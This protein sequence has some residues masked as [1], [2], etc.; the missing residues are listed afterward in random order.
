MK[1]TNDYHPPVDPASALAL[2][3]HL[4]AREHGA[5]LQQLAL[6]IRDWVRE[7]GAGLDLHVWQDDRAEKPECSDVTQSEGCTRLYSCEKQCADSK[8]WKQGL[9]VDTAGRTFS[10]TVNSS[11]QSRRLIEEGL[12]QVMRTPVI[13][14]EPRLDHP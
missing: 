11:D 7:H 14:S 10:I 12:I 1:L 2:F 13:I 5:E 3:R 4:R 6:Y 9:N 8:E